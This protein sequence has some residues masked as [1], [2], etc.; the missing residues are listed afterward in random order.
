MLKPLCFCKPLRFCKRRVAFSTTVVATSIGDSSGSY[1][2][3][4]PDSGLSH[5]RYRALR[6]ILSRM[7]HAAFHMLCTAVRRFVTGRSVVKLPK[8][9]NLWFRGGTVEE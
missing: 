1:T 5:T 8:P 2:S 6:R 3:G 9:D 7:R 4:M